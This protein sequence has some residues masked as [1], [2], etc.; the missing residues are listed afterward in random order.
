MQPSQDNDSSHSRHRTGL[1][2][3]GTTNRQRRRQRM[4]AAQLHIAV[5][6]QHEE[7]RVVDFTCQELEQ[8][9]QALTNIEQNI[10][11]RDSQPEI[12]GNG[13]Q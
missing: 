3:H 12:P 13:D 4:L 8:Q 9:Q 5:C 11:Q 6:P 2:D 10:Q 7:R 1:A